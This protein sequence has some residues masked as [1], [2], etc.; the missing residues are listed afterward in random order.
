MSQPSSAPLAMYSSIFALSLLMRS[1]D[2]RSSMTKSVHRWRKS[3]CCCLGSPVTR[4]FR[5]QEA[6]G[7]RRAPLGRR[8]PVLE[9]PTSPRPSF[10]RPHHKLGCDL[11]I[12]FTGYPIGGR[13][14]D[15]LSLSRAL[16]GTVFVLLAEGDKL[17]VGHGD[18]ARVQN[19]GR[20]RFE[21]LDH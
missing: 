18:A 3:C 12:L 5:I 4:S 2:E 10:F 17:V 7:D 9:S 11:R 20:H 14:D 13:H 19:H 15:D 6:S 16:H 21:I 1:V 8:K